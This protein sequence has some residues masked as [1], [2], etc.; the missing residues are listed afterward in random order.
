MTKWTILLCILITA[1]FAKSSAPEYIGSN[2]CKSCHK[3]EKSGAQ[4]LVWQ[5]SKHANAFDVL[6]TDEASKIAKEKGLKNLPHEAP[7]CLECHT[8]G[9][10]KGGYEVKDEAFWNPA[11]DDTQGKKAV[12]RMKNLKHVG[13]EVCHG[14]GSEYKKKKTMKAIFEGTKN[15]TDFGLTTVT[16]ETC[17]QCHNERSPSFKEFNY[18]ERKKEISHPF[19][20]GFRKTE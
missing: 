17:K 18:E 14:P 8:V 10:G 9:F 4:Y 12:K 20:E 3:K 13:C 16:E 2:K 6:L 7:E 5:E 1:G 11:D 15:G 19:P